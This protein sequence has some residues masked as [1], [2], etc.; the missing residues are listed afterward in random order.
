MTFHKD[1]SEYTDQLKKGMIQRAY[2]GLMDYMQ[3]L[4]AHFSS[5]YPEYSVPGSLYFG[6]MDMTYFAI[7]PEGFKERG[8]KIAVVYLHEAGRFE[9]WLSGYNRQIQARYWTIVKESG[10]D[11]YH[12]VA[13]PQGFDSVLEHILVTEP[14]FDDL[15]GLT[16][17]IEKGTLEFIHDVEEFLKSKEV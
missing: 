5:R 6:Y 14:N 12:L 8:L 7:V 4:R 3:S 17:R 11:T 9:V 1:M 13:A 2:R 15:E 16:A 10:W